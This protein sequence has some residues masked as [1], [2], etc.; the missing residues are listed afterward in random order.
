MHWEE[1]GD[2]EIAKKSI[3]LKYKVMKLQPAGGFSE[4]QNQIAITSKI[5]L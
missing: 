5:F 4:E 3:L 2:V 1:D